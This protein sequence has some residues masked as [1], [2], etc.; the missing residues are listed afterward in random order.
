MKKLISIVLAVMTLMG[1][2]IPVF[3]GAEGNIRYVNCEDGKRLNVREAPNGKLAYRI[4]CGTEVEIM[5]TV[6]APAGWAYVRVD[7]HTNGGFVMTKYLVTSKPGKYEITE[8]ADN[9]VEVTPYTVKAK[10]INSRTEK[11]VGLRESPNKTAHAIRRLE[12]GD[13]LQVI[14]RGKTWSRVLDPTTGKTGYVANDY[15]VKE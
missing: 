8:R 7:G 9:F 12:A 15:M 13:T 11:S 6:A 2:M 3:A 4:A 1:L 5:P 10:A 14:A